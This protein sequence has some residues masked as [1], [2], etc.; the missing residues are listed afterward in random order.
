[1]LHAT[2]EFAA[3]HKVVMGHGDG[4]CVQVEDIRMMRDREG[5]LRGFCYVEFADESGALAGRGLE[6]VRRHLEQWQ[7]LGEGSRG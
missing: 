3:E 7:Q 1:M 2:S 5:N 6:G 4:A